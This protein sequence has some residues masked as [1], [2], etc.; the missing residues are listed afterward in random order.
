MKK[1]EKVKEAKAL[2]DEGQSFESLIPIYSED[3]YKRENYPDATE[4]NDNT[5]FLKT[6]R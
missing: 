6:D 5:S 2:L 4:Q 3:Y 1:Y